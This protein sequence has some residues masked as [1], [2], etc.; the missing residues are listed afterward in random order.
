MEEKKK[1]NRTMYILKDNRAANLLAKDGFVYIIHELQ[2]MNLLE[3]LLQIML[4]YV[5]CYDRMRRTKYFFFF[6]LMF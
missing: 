5:R 4:G 1:K 6:F 3:K 2:S